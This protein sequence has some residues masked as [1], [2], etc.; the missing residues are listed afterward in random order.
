[1]TLNCRADSAPFSHPHAGEGC[2]S[3]RLSEVLEG[4]V[5]HLPLLLG[6]PGLLV[7]LSEQMWSP[8]HA[9]EVNLKITLRADV[10]AS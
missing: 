3:K 2:P 10:K 4:G 9:G 7:E 6:T 5:C 8:P 1:M